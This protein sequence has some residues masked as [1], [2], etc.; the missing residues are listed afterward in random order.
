ML[1]EFGVESREMN[2]TKVVE[3]FDI[4][5]Q[6]IYTPSYNQW[7]RSY[8]LCKLGVLSDFPVFRTDQAT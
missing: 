4:F 3:N 8:V 2:N 1:T 6:S 5:L 7:I